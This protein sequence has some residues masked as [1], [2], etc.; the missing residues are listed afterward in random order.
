MPAALKVSAAPSSRSTTV[1]TRSMMAPSARTASIAFMD[2]PPVVVTS[3]RMT[4]RLPL[5]VS[6][7][8][9]PS[10]SLRAPCSLACLRTKKAGERP[11]L[12]LARN[13]HGGRQRH[14]AHL[15]PADQVDLRALQR[16]EDQRGDQLRALRVQHGGLHVEVEA[17]RAPRHELG[18]APGGEG[19]R[20]DDL[21]QAALCG[22]GVG[23]GALR[24]TWSCRAA[25][26][27]PPEPAMSSREPRAKEG[28]S[29]ARIASDA[30]RAAKSASRTWPTSTRAR[31]CTA[32]SRSA[33]ARAC[34]PTR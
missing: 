31:G 13:G 23:H 9:R 5:S 28:C 19:A 11:A 22:A 34:G 14:G 32:R 6:P 24:L 26:R 20:L 15:Q 27:E 1:I 7:G 8:A 3:S 29:T 30:R 17:G 18:L 33:R 2:E 21:D 10:T 25:A 16:L 12:G 4:T